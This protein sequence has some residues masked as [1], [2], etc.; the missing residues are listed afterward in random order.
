MI[1]L[2]LYRIYIKCRFRYNNFCVINVSHSSRHF[3]NLKDFLLYFIYSQLNYYTYRVITSISQS[4]Q[5]YKVIRQSTLFDSSRI[6]KSPHSQQFFFKLTETK[7]NTN[8]FLVEI[9]RNLIKTLLSS[10]YQN[11]I[12]NHCKILKLINEHK[13]KKIRGNVFKEIR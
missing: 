1:F 2:K 4:Y 9:I 3:Y 11:R 12:F 6:S 5:H 7:N 8:C 13:N 10:H